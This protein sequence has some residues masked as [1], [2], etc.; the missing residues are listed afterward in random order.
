MAEI[1]YRRRLHTHEELVHR[2]SISSS[3]QHVFTVDVYHH[4]VANFCAE[5]HASVRY[6]LNEIGI[7]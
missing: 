7:N 5:I 3:H 1:L 6:E 2:I 4:Q